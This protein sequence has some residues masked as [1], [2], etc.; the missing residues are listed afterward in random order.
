MPGTLAEIV[1][2]AARRFGDRT[3]LVVEDRS[4][5]F[6]EVD[7][8]ANRL[9][10]GL[11]AMGIEAGDRITLYAPNSW[12]WLIAYY[13]ALKTGAVINPINVML[14]AEEVQFVVENCEA[15]A[16]LAGADKGEALMDV[17]AATPLQ[18]VILFGDGAPAG[19]RSF[20]TVL[21]DAD[22]TFEAATPESGEMATICYTSGTTGHP[23]GAMLS[24]D[25]VLA[26]TAMT[27]L[28]H[29]RTGHDTTVTALPCAHVY[30]NVLMNA[31]FLYGTKFVLVPRFEEAAVL[32]AI[33]T[34][35]A[36]MF[37][38]VPTAFFYLLAYPDLD[39]YDLSSLTRCSVGGQT[40]PAAKAEE[41]EAK[42]GCPILELWG[43]TELAGP[44][45]CNTF[46]GENR[47]GSIGLP[48]PNVECRIGDIADAAKTMPAGEVGEL[49][50]RG[51]IVMNGYFGNEAATKETI[52]ADGWLHSGDLAKIDDDGFFHIVDRKKDM[53]LTA[54][55]NVY[56]AELERVVSMH[57]AVAMVGVG[58]LPD[59][60]KGEIAK[61]YIVLK[62]GATCSEADIEALCREHLAAYKVPR[63]VQFVDDLPKTSTGKIMRRHLKTLDA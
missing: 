44:A 48:L 53:I 52:E 43:M 34:H 59:E 56:P 32:E 47:H 28:M 9:A 19:A 36:T 55:F 14:T 50:C 15:K 37:D 41:F 29:V 31:T 63:A 42:V 16:I 17:K 21:A 26:S 57:P 60:T 51:P 38:G 5:T 24:H 12:E 10:N 62:P 45:T 40:M 58:S 1:G 6:N 8:L 3:A 46:Y 20:D 54:G 13:G 35:R 18:E 30:G 23:K 25:A 7:Q 11:T 49:M 27:A 33:Q 2:T 4:F 39:K 61:A 22:P